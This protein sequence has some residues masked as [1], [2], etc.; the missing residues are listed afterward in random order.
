MVFF[1]AKTSQYKNYPFTDAD[2]LRLRG[3]SWLEH[4]YI[5]PRYDNYIMDK[6]E[7]HT[8]DKKEEARAFEKS[9]NSRGNVFCYCAWNLDV[10]GEADL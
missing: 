5:K 10:A 9:G 8:I 7:S 2:N 4:K 3:E 6:I 1:A